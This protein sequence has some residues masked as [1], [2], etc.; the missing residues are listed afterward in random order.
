[1]SL[2]ERGGQTQCAGRRIAKYYKGIAS[3]GHPEAHPFLLALLDDWGGHSCQK[4]KERSRDS[5]KTDEAL[6]ALDPA[7]A[8]V[9]FQSGTLPPL[10]VHRNASLLF[11]ESPMQPFGGSLGSAI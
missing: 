5:T 8:G 2:C 4:Q 9:F 6:Q 7:L 1:M 10:V 3:H 11:K